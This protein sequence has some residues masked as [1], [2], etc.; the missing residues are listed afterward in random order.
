[1]INIFL[2]FSLPL[3]LNGVKELKWLDPLGRRPKSYEDWRR[4]VGEIKETRI[5]QVV[6]SGKENLVAL[7]VNAEIYPDLIPEINQFTEDLQNEGYSVRID[8]IRGLSPTALRNY[9]S[10]ISNLKGAIFIGEVPVAW[11]ESYGFGV[12]E[13]PI[14]LYFMDLNGNWLDSDND[15]KFDGHTGDVNP[16]IWV[17]RLSARSLIWDSEVRLLKIYFRKNHLYRTGNLSLPRRALSYVDDDWQ[18]FGDCSLSL[19]YSDVTVVE[20]PDQ[21][22]AADYRNRLTEGYEWI[23]VCAHSSPWGHTF[24][25]PSGYSGTVSNSEIFALQPSALFLNLFACSGTRFVE[26]NYSAGWYIFQDPYG[27]LAVGSSKVGSMLYFSD[28]YRPLGR[29]SSIGSAFKSWFTINGQRSRPWFYGLNI[30]GDPTLKPNLSQNQLIRRKDSGKSLN[31]EIVSPSSETDNSPAVISTPDGK[32]WVAWTTGRNPTNGR[33]DIYSAYRDASWRDAGSIGPHTYWDLYPSLTIDRNNNPIC[34]W[35]HFDYANNH[36]AYN[37][38]YSVY[39]TSWSPKQR[40][41]I[42]SSCALNSNLCRDS[43]LFVRVFFQTRRTGNLDIYTSIYSGTS[44]SEPTPVTSSTYDEI[45]PNSLVA[46]NGRVWVFYNRYL[47]DGS[48][49]FASYESA[50]VWREIGPIS[51]NQNRAFR[52]SATI[53]GRERIWVCWQSFDEGNGNIYGSYW[54]GRGFS[55]PQRIT[56]DT[57]NDLFLDMAS[58]NTGRPF[59]VWQSN[60]DGNWNI[61][62]SYYTNGNWV[63]E[64]PVHQN[65][66]LDINPKITVRPNGEIWVIWQNF[67]NNNWEIVARRIEPSAIKESEKRMGRKISFISNQLTL[68]K[69]EIYNL[70]GRKVSKRERLN[71]GIYILKDGNRYQ[72]IILIR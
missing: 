28:F 47:P 41:V 58:D 38:Y 60:R 27:L 52:P 56:S 24:A 36:S 17:G 40:F 59:L 32:I 31:F 71:S 12:E 34:V 62:Y 66:G 72:R 69:G 70:Q 64:E 50:G 22:T 39:Q 33:F 35:S 63:R 30:L 7:I 26:E 67:T 10:S 51:Q 68:Q 44:W 42:D 25:I 16:E 15:G 19:V 20:L 49:I 48:K 8:T 21:T 4:E 37:L 55:P 29:D 23:Q 61:Y 43:S 1:M 9:L 46:Q 5:G 57:L 65:P 3:F 18:G 53:E 2:L 11:C 14:D 45:N 13:Y 6:Q 54:D